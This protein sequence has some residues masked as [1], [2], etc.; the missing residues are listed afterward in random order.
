[1]KTKKIKI[2]NIYI[3]GGDPVRVQSMTKTK[4]TDWRVTVAQ[5]N[6]L[7]RCGC[8]I[9]R[10]AVPDIE[11]ARAISKIKSHIKI[12][13]VADIHFDWR[14]AVEAIENGADKIRINPGN[15]GSKENIAK[16]VAAAKKRKIPIRVGVNAGSLKIL[17]GSDSWLRM[18]PQ[19]RAER[20][21]KELSDY[22]KM[23]EGMNFY[24]LAVSLKANDVATTVAA[25]RIYSG[26]MNYPVHLGVTEA[27]TEFSGLVKS[28]SAFGILLNEGIGDTI[29]VSLTAGPEEEVKAG[30]EILKALGLRKRGIEIIS[31]PTCAR[32][33]TDLIKI[34]HQLEN[35]LVACRLSLVTSPLK[36]AVMG[37]AVNGPGEARD[38]DVGIAGGRGFGL[39]FRKG[40]IVKKI[41]QER[42]VDEILEEIKN[43]QKKI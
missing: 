22:V 23:F 14:L 34:V 38:A 32:C 35:K 18:T 13:L 30:W 4:T 1:M 9:I 21:V 28:A 27:G 20:M 16:I 17:K 12:P 40:K 7:A 2:G 8:E 15:I 10:V 42:F 25:N 29:R 33:E 31:C 11:S 39:L 26:V 5:I 43:V 6:E 36:I 3:G 19:K 24:D 41:P 37:C